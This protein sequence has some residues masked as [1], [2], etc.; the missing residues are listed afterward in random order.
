MW[1]WP[2]LSSKTSS[3]ASPNSMLMCEIDVVPR[4]ELSTSRQA[5]NNISIGLVAAGAGESTSAE[6]SSSDERRITE[7]RICSNKFCCGD[8]DNEDDDCCRNFID[9][10][11]LINQTAD[12]NDGQRPKK[13]N[14]TANRSCDFIEYYD[15]YEDYNKLECPDSPL[16]SIILTSD[17]S[18]RF[19]R[20][21]PKK[22][23]FYCEDYDIYTTT[24]KLPSARIDDKSQPQLDYE[25]LSDIEC[26]LDDTKFN[27]DRC[28]DYNE[29]FRSAQR[30]HE[31]E[32]QWHL[33]DFND[34]QL[35]TRM[36]EDTATIAEY[37]KISNDGSIVLHYL[38]VEV[39]MAQST[40]QGDRN[41]IQRVKWFFLR[42]R[43]I[44]EDHKV[45][46][47][48]SSTSL[49]DAIRQKLV[50]SIKRSMKSK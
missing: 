22:L 21:K 19:V 50:A 40:L 12:S 47:K 37:Y 34:D 17:I 18:G 26:S 31:C 42:G 1:K 43:E 35:S 29:R 6:K 4:T 33:E 14:S 3:P 45:R 10:L 39:E 7:T 15:P 5:L 16:N 48:K 28:R 30:Q 13:V 41:L 36:N 38:S 25:L 8:R 9:N 46:N 24:D 27:L 20:L 2:K 49:L 44:T 23:R 32:C 11:R